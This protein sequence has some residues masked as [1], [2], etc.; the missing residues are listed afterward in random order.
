MNIVLDK[1]YKTKSGLKVKIYSLDNGGIGSVHGAFLDPCGD[2]VLT[3]WTKSGTCLISSK[4][5]LVEVSEYEDFK[6]DDRVYVWNKN[7]NLKFRRH[8]AGVGEKTGKP[9]TFFDGK[10]SWS[11]GLGQT[12]TVW[13]YCEKA[14]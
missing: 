11:N 5:D 9:M 7:S 2:W 8:F 10:T 6:I 13:D 3:C 14:D 4:Q 1:A 12:P